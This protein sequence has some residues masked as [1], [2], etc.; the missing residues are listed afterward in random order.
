MQA[1]NCLKTPN[2][3]RYREY[4][5]YAHKTGKPVDPELLIVSADDLIIH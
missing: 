3:N 2:L 4:G 5:F 1:L